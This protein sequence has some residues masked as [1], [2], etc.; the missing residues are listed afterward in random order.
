MKLIGGGNG[1]E[2]GKCIHLFQMGIKP[3]IRLSWVDLFFFSIVKTSSCELSSY[4]RIASL[5][6]FLFFL[7]RATHV[8]PHVRCLFALENHPCHED[9]I[10]FG[11]TSKVK[12]S[13]FRFGIPFLSLFQL[14]FLFLN[15]NLAFSKRKD[16][17]RSRRR[18]FRTLLVLLHFYWSTSSF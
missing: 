8:L 14:L 9:D 7:F 13:N 4:I 18:E 16:F 15:F 12:K 1:Y 11:L 3:D 2:I 6:D 17:P 5:T 10:L